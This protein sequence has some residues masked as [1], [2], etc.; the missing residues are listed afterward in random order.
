MLKRYLSQ[1]AAVRPYFDATL[2]APLEAVEREAPH[3]PVFQI[4]TMESL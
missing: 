3:H 2:D 1:V 4:T